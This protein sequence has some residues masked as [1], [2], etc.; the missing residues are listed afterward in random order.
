MSV[1]ESDSEENEFP[2][3][4]TE[5]VERAR[6]LRNQLSSVE[7]DISAVSSDSDSSDSDREELVEDVWSTNH[8]LVQVRDFTER[9]GAI[10]QIPEDGTALDFFQLLFPENLFEILLEET[11]RFAVQSFRTK[12]DAR[13]YPTT[14]EEMRAFVAL[15]IF[16]GIKCLPETR[17][18]W[19]D[20]SVLGVSAVKKVM[21]RSRFEKIRQYL[22]MNDRERL[23]PRGDQAHDKLYRCN[24]WLCLC[25]ASVHWERW[26][27][28]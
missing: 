7:S 28:T 26:A 16:F 13:W 17:L 23:P 8:S 9:T 2:G 3:F 15:K 4:E 19:S 14:L 21:P 5:K 11:N 24:K 27:P 22:H 6:L 18:Y 25:I 12:P 10:S 20:N 1:I